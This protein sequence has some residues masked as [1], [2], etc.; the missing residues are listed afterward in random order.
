MLL[1]LL[2]KTP[3]MTIYFEVNKIIFDDCK[4]VLAGLQD[5]SVKLSLIDPPYNASTSKIVVDKI[6]YKT[7]GS[8]DQDFDYNFEPSILFPEYKRVSEKNIALV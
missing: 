8:K 7:V 4:N 2:R 6:H 5:K 3:N 1:P